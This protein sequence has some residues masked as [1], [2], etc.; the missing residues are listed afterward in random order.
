MEVG[1]EQDFT[2]LFTEIYG[3]EL[4]YGIFLTDY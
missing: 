2:K 4:S 1:T 3:I